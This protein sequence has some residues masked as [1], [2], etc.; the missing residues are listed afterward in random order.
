MRL[1]FIAD[2]R[3]EHPRRWVRY[4]VTVGDEV[5][6]LSTYPCSNTAGIRIKTLPGFFRAG[7]AFVKRSDIT[8]RAGNGRIVT[9]LTARRLFSNA[10]S[11]WQQ[12]KVVDF[13]CQARVSRKTLQQFNPA[14][15]HAI[16]IQNEGYVAALAGARPWI[17][18]IWGQDFVFLAR[19]CLV[20]RLLTSWAVRRPDGLTADCYRDIRLAQE[21]GLSD[22]VPV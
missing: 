16:R 14:V 7:N 19:T 1:A 11:I 12:M 6:L 10:I 18:S 5:L 9:W 21:A 17:L 15:V 8:E 13:F 22:T 2:G 20:H 4:F 3:A